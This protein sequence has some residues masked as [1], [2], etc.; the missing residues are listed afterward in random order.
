MLW[1]IVGFVYLL[2]I[3][4]L[5]FLLWGREEKG[6]DA[7][8]KWDALC[9]IVGTAVLAYVNVSVEIVRRR[10]SYV[11]WGSGCICAVCVHYYMYYCSGIMVCIPDE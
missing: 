4:S 11:V 9:I 1:P 5:V 3:V 10:G 8:V 6:G 2:I 7:A